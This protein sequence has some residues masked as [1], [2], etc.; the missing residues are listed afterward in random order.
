[1]NIEQHNSKDKEK[2]YISNKW[3]GGIKSLPIQVPFGIENDIYTR[4]PDICLISY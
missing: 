3:E 1:M 2:V 4:V